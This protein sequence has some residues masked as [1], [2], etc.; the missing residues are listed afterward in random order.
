MN[1][2]SRSLPITLLFL[3]LGSLLNCQILQ[4]D[5]AIPKREIWHATESW[6]ESWEQRYSD[7]VAS[8]PLNF[9]EI[10]KIAVDCADVA[11][12]LRW[13]FARIHH[14]PI[15]ATLITST[16][17]FNFDHQSGLQVKAWRNIPSN[18]NN[19]EKDQL[20][21]TALKYVLLNTATITLE[22]D[23]YPLNVTNQTLRPG[24]INFLGKHT[25]V[26]NK[27]DE[28]GNSFP[29]SIIQATTPTEI[30]PLELI[31]LLEFRSIIQFRWYELDPI[32]KKFSQRDP[33]EMPNYLAKENQFDTIG[34]K[35]ILDFI[36]TYHL[37]MTLDPKNIITEMVGSFYRNAF[38]RIKLVERGFDY[39]VRQH[40]DCS[41]DSPGDENWS[42]PDRDKKLLKMFSNSESVLAYL[43]LQNPAI[44]FKMHFSDYLTDLKLTISN[45]MSTQDISLNQFIQNL[46]NGTA[47]SNPSDPIFVRWGI[48][49]NQ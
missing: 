18:P 33:S 21:I 25:Q 49:L 45:G 9:F 4:A 29:I 6:D 5:E 16:S 20:F 12:G 43:K 48:N 42:T 2:L 15:A 36:K 28:T 34:G 38:T 32:T 26:I 37:D 19:W 44:D 23:T 14:L 31:T 11:Y 13:I 30:R 40:K 7:W 10:H 35:N 8:L 27:V 47:T 22:H 39:C 46:K 24:V 41:A 17:T 3:F 1:N